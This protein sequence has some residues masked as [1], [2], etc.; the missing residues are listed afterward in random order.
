M[1]DRILGR[2]VVPEYF[3]GPKLRPDPGDVSRLYKGGVLPVSVAMLEDTVLGQ[4]L[5]ERVEAFI[6]SSV[7]N[8]TFADA[9]FLLIEIAATYGSPTEQRNIRNAYRR[10]AKRIHPDA[11]HSHESDGEIRRLNQLMGKVNGAY[12]ELSPNRS[13]LDAFTA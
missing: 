6:L 4:S 9:T 5:E 2:R 1:V 8:Q 13:K 7:S 11:D 10:L 3:P 12:R